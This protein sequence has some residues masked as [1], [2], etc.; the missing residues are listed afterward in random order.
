M[1]EVVIGVV[2]D[3]TAVAA[4]MAV[5][6]VAATVAGVVMAAGVIVDR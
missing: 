2:G 3:I 5:T 4:F 1:V 6:E